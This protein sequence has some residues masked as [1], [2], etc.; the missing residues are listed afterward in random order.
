[1]PRTSVQIK[2]VFSVWS[3]WCRCQ[4]LCSTVNSDATQHHIKLLRQSSNNMLIFGRPVN[5]A[6]RKLSYTFWLHQLIRIKLYEYIYR[7]HLF[8]RDSVQRPK[9][10]SQYI[11]A[12][13]YYNFALSYDILQLRFCSDIFCYIIVSILL[14]FALSYINRPPCL[15]A[16]WHELPYGL[17][18]LCTSLNPTTATGNK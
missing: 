17:R 3:R 1:M 2:V 11:L 16:V 12:L 7:K 13:P 18:T 6:T 9:R 10:D 15:R 8:Q 14:R 4:I 5:F